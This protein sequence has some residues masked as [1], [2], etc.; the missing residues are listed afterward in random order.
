MKVHRILY[1]NA[2]D[3]FF[4]SH[5]HECIHGAYICI[6]VGRYSEQARE[7]DC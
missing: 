7:R 3:L 6:E 5:F 2:N 1:T 4:T